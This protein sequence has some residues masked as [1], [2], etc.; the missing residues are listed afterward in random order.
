MLCWGGKLSVDLYG[1][2]RKE[3]LIG[4][5]KGGNVLSAIL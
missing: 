2:Q 5:G 3:V 1:R 4:K